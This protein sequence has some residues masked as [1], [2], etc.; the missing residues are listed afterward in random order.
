[1][2]RI[3]YILIGMLI[4]SITFSCKKALNAPPIEF[5]YGDQFWTSRASVE[6]A[7]A[8]MYGQLRAGL[9]GPVNTG[10]L[11][12]SY[13]I[14]GDL[15]AG[16]FNVPPI[17]EGGALNYGVSATP[18]N[19]RTPWNFSY[20]L[21]RTSDLQDW[22]RFYRVI[23]LCNL[24][25]EKV[26]AMPTN[27][28]QDKAQQNSYV[29]EAKFVRAYT[30]FTITRIWGDPVYVSKTYND[31]DYG[32]VPPVP[33]SPEAAV[34]DSCLNDLRY[35]KSVLPFSGGDPSKTTR[36]NRGSVS[37]LM[38]HIFAWKHNYDSAHYYAQEVIT[39]GGYTLEPMSSYLNIWKG[40]SSRESIFEMP[41]QFNASDPH[42]KDDNN[43]S[44]EATFG[45][46]AF[47]LKGSIVNN[48]RT[49]C[50][51]S[52]TGTFIDF[53]D[54]TVQTRDSLPST[55]L[56][57]TVRDER[58]KVA[59]KLMNASGGDLKGYMLLKYSN[60]NYQ[61][62]DTKS[63]PY[64]NNN[65]VLFRLSDMYLLDAEALAYKGDLAGAKRNLAFTQDRAGINTYTV[66][67][68]AFDVQEEVIKERGR[69]FIGEG[70]W[71]YDLIRNQNPPGTPHRWLE[72][73]GYQPA[74]VTPEN[75]GYY[76]P[77]DMNTLFPY[78]NL[79][80]QNPWWKNNAG[81]L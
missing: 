62:P 10:I 80:V 41:M 9:R 19:S 27:L 20:V 57:D 64:I 48:E 28:F 36:G 68:N 1:M 69:E 39:K 46:F 11:G 24:I 16:L 56:F 49:N 52:P 78:D 79:L 34:L 59:L 50:W 74:R 32:K 12:S 13:F 17:P 40:K 71:F 61:S 77:I 3:I 18:T 7:T 55:T 63:F 75:K 33:R 8:A 2:K 22:S 6:Q 53:K 66:P 37:A 65:L 26:S 43:P 70:I 73:L 31:V 23:A 15:T 14:F 51:I 58:T 72:F 42:S 4:I 54:R 76:W 21:Q 47:F 67:T 29:A 60:F 81:R 44:S 30:Y 38:A 5:T 45:G 25:M 35:A